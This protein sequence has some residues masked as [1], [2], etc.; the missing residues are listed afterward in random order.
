MLKQVF[1][2]LTLFVNLSLLEA[3]QA[4]ILVHGAFT[5]KNTWMQ[6]NSKFYKTLQKT[7]NSLAHIESFYWDQPFEGIFAFEKINAGKK[8]AD[9][10]IK[11]RNTGYNHIEVY[12]HSYGGHVVAI[13][14]QLLSSENGK[15]EIIIQKEKTN[16]THTSLEAS[17]EYQEAHKL[18]QDA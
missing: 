11:L 7:S 15:L 18:F 10:V 5:A 3:K 2:G 12:A 13:A 17:D 8:L 4:I 14:S 1:I 16:K 6:P 9:L